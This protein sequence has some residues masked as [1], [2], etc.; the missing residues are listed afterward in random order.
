M[1]PDNEALTTQKSLAIITE[2]I[3][4]TKGNIRNNSVYFLLWGSVIALANLG[5]FALLMARYSRPYIVWVIIIPAWLIS[6]YI[7]YRQSK[8]QRMATHLDRINMW[9]WL[10][11]GVV[12]FTLVGFGRAVNYQLNPIILVISALPTLL[13]GVMIKFRPLIVGG[14]CFWI[15]GALSFVLGNPWQPLLGAL[16]VTVGYIIPGIMLRIKEA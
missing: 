16:A 4:L 2:M 15:C 10:C 9:M 13:S 11:F 12:I 7:G 6:L 1:K 14:I 8:K 5:M 3:S